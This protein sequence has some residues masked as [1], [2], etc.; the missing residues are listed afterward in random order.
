MRVLVCGAGRVGYGIAR[1]LASEKNAVTVIDTR[2]ELIDQLT[3]ELDVRGVVG[4]GSHP[5]VLE[6]AG[7]ADADM[8]IAVTHS[9][10]VNMVACEVA[11]ALFSTP[12]RL[13]RIRDRSYLD[14]AWRDLFATGNL[15]IDVIISPEL[16]VGRAI[17][18]RLETPG[19]FNTLPFANGRIVILGISLDEDS[20]VAGSTLRQ[21]AD[22]FPALKAHVVGIKRDG[23]LFTP[24]PDD[25]VMAGDDLYVSAEKTNVSRT[26]DIFGID[27]ARAR[28]V[29][30]VGGGNIGMYVAR[31]LEQRGVRV[32]VIEANRQQAERAAETL[33]RTVVLH[34]DGLNRQ[35]L[36]EAGAQTA[37][38]VIA[39]T[40]D[41]KVNVLAAVLAKREGVKR[42]FCLVNDKT[43][44]ALR[45][46][47]DID[48]FIDPRTTTVSTILQ[49][50]RRGR[51]TGLFSVGDGEA[52]ALEGV[53]LETS[54]MVGRKWS[55]LNLPDGVALAGVARDGQ[56]L[57]PS[58]D[59]TIQQ[60]DHVVV[61]AERDQVGEVERLFRVSAAYF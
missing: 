19:A 31:E 44:E 45:D 35:I 18:R 29:V 49:H 9:D 16:E 20:P 41:D 28:R 39:L 24:K 51:I 3:T 37:E 10:E 47:M 40:N 32:R 42:A 60:G 11:H 57:M 50:V 43:Y 58:A 25:P 22:L 12:H 61:F 56:I 55:Q 23:R 30:V 53:A 6:R 52:E 36:R 4:H 34:G 2:P 26:L 7:A 17:L 5:D 27:V 1:E 59:L 13:A 21:I 38:V 54:P 15:P 14:P 48:V 33:R 46:A 8:I